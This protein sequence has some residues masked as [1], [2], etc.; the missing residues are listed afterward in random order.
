MRV[1]GVRGENGFFIEGMAVGRVA[2]ANREKLRCPNEVNA[3][4]QTLASRAA[5]SMEGGKDVEYESF[6]AALETAE[7][8]CDRI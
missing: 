6:E 2:D 5:V 7:V 8:R 4:D 3:V 1:D